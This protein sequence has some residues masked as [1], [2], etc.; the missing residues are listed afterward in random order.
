MPPTA[1]THHAVARWTER[2]DRQASTNEARFAISQFL[3]TGQRRPTP[4]HWM[5]NTKP[6]PSVV[7][8]YCSKRP[9]VCLVIKNGVVVTVIT[10]ELTQATAHHLKLV[11]QDRRPPRRRLAPVD[12]HDWRREGYGDIEQEA[13]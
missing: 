12:R 6:Q 7:F 13:A 2:V 5:A 4:R 10:R 11:Q 1:V 9:R 8:V 3:C